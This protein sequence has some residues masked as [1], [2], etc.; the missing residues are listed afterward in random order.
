MLRWVLSLRRPWA[1]ARY[2]VCFMYWSIRV[3]NVFWAWVWLVP[4][5][6]PPPP[7][8]PSSV[9]PPGVDVAPGLETMSALAMAC[10]ASFI[11]L[12]ISFIF[13]SI[14]RVPSRLASSICLVTSPLPNV[15]MDVPINRSDSKEPNWSFRSGSLN[16]ASSAASLASSLIRSFNRWT[17][18]AVTL[19]MVPKSETALPVSS[20][21]LAALG[22]ILIISWVTC[23]SRA[24][25]CALSAVLS[26]ASSKSFDKEAYSFLSC[27]IFSFWA[28][29][30]F[31]DSIWPWIAL[32]VRSG[33][34]SRYSSI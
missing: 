30:A 6:P 16:L 4:P 33:S 23:F 10:S 13:L 3:F 11:A 25:F 12:L 20:K 14:S 22:K 17:S 19:T 8:V 1:L 26:L 34:L 21:P 31:I 32:W 24:V 29:A 5:P 15:L 28:V 2:S 9:T 18:F 27:S 7:P